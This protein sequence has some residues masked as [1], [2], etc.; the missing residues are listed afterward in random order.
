MPLKI[1][2]R[3]WQK[4][5]ITSITH[6][7][8]NWFF[9]WPLQQLFSRDNRGFLSVPTLIFILD[10]K[11]SVYKYDWM[12]NRI[13][14]CLLYELWICTS[15]HT[16]MIRSL[17]ICVKWIVINNKVK[18]LWDLFIYKLVTILCNSPLPIYFPSNLSLS[19]VSLK[20]CFTVTCTSLSSDNAGSLSPVNSL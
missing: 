1:I 15:I 4:I 9:I 3:E 8:I 14:I 5:G 17:T 6:P 7:Q 12:Q 13:Q 11:N 18:T 20:S 10:R 16:W 19:N 2:Y